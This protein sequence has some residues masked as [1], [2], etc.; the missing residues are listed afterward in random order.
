MT[1]ME[2]K[3]R[4]L[5]DQFIPLGA[6]AL[7]ENYQRSQVIM[8]TSE[9][10]SGPLVTCIDTTGRSPVL[11]GELVPVDWHG[12][13]VQVTN[14]PD[15]SSEVFIELGTFFFFFF[16]FLLNKS[17]QGFPWSSSDISIIKRI[18]RNRNHS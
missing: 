9:D 6:I 15:R 18:H 7:G 12:L 14:R 13:P 10:R 16:F 8:R 4:L 3:E 5:Q 11:C 1:S 2:V 17:H